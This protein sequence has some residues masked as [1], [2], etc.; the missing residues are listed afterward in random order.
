MLCLQKLIFAMFCIDFD[1]AVLNIDVLVKETIEAYKNKEL[2][3]DTSCE[4]S[5]L[6]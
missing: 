6:V 5:V 4:V 1:I 3:M 2:E